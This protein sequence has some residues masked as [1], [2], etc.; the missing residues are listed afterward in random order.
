MVS[1]G[2]L[3]FFIVLYEKEG[4]RRK[5]YFDE[6]ICLFI[7]LFTENRITEFIEWVIIRTSMKDS[8]N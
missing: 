7:K 6:N 1:L 8:I 3:I 4:K 2:V 5:W